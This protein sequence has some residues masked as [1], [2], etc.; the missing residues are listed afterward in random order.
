MKK[1]WVY[2]NEQLGKIVGYKVTDGFFSD[3][4]ERTQLIESE[5]PPAIGKDAIIVAVNDT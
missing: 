1:G 2:F 3:I 5:T 4:T